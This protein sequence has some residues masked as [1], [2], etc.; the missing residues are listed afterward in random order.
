[1]NDRRPTPPTSPIAGGAL[2]AGAGI[3][4]MLALLMGDQSS[5]GLGI[6]FGAAVGLVVGAAS[7]ALLSGWTDR[8]PT[9][10]S[11][12]SGGRGGPER[13]GTGWLGFLGFLGFLAPIVSP[14][15]VAFFGFFLF[16]S[17]FT[18][19]AS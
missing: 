2:V 14:L 12:A 3:G 6:A 5:L 10:G 7:Q 18:R 13:R 1:M 4:A 17:R 8:G 15:F 11:S 16:F 9:D 19:S